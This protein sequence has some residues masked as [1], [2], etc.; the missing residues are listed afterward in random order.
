MSVI[1]I[2]SIIQTFIKIINKCGNK[3]I[4][5]CLFKRALCNIKKYKKTN[6]I[7]YFYFG[8][9][10][11]RPFCE[12]K[13]LKVGGKIYKIPVEIK[14]LKQKSLIIKWLVFAIQQKHDLSYKTKLTKECIDLNNLFGNTVRFCEDYNKLIEINKLFIS[15][16]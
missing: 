3:N 7:T 11:V 1:F 9:Y 13:S 5:E 15:Y 8:L 16:R 6:A 10:K 12:L 14:P 2:N 4:C